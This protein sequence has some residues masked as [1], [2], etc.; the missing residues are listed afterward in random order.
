M[1]SVRPLDRPGPKRGAQHPRPGRASGELSG[2]QSG[3]VD[4]RTDQSSDATADSRGATWSPIVSLLGGGTPEVHSVGGTKVFPELLTTC[5]AARGTA[6]YP[7]ITRT[8]AVD[9]NRRL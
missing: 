9:A 1:P 2:F 6:H 3:S 5:I 7:E 4:P 8:L